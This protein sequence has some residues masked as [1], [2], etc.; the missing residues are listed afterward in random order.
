MP[1]SRHERMRTGV[2]RWYWLSLLA[3]LLAMLSKSSVATLPAVLL[4]VVWW[5]SRRITIGD[6]VRT[7]PFFFVA[8]GLI[9]VEI[10]FQGHGDPHAHAP[11]LVRL[12]GSGAVIWFYL[13]KALLPIH[14]SFVYPHWTIQ[15]GQLQWWLPLVAAIA[16]WLLLWRQRNH[17]W[18][19]ALFFA[20][21]YFCVALVPVMGF[22]ET[23][24]LRIAPTADHYQH[25]ALIA[26]VAL[27]A[28]GWSY[29]RS[30][31]AP[32]AQW[33]PSVPAV[34]VIAILA[35][36]AW[37]RSSLFGNPITL[38]QDSLTTNPDSWLAHINAGLALDKA[39]RIEDAIGHFR[40]AIQLQPAFAE[41]YNNLG[42]ELFKIGRV[43]E[44]KN[45]YL[46]A[47]RIRPDYPE[48]LDNLGVC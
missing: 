4:L 22:A 28:A 3:F 34:A 48:A 12:A 33:W 8:A 2:G 13:A 42:L 38:F 1:D 6:F 25:L 7:L 30:H 29:W 21:T 26:V 37:Q 16:V 46:E 9:A 45:Q 20:W 44:A 18:G 23:G 43:P 39:G 15:T 35:V 17:A 27:A 40:Q 41:G 14:Q 32:S 31:A 36:A 5:R 47:L 11:F 10:W 19:R 24:A